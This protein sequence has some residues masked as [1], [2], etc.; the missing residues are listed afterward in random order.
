MLCYC[1]LSLPGP[2]H[3][4]LLHGLKCVAI[5]I[6]AICLPSLPLP[7]VCE[8]IAQH[9]TSSSQT[10]FLIL[11]R[12]EFQW[13]C[14]VV[15]PWRTRLAGEWDVWWR[16]DSIRVLHLWGNKFTQN[17]LARIRSRKVFAAI[18]CINIE[19][20]MHFFNITHIY[21]YQVVHSVTVLSVQ[22]ESLH[23]PAG[24]DG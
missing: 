21:F 23:T 1:P 8:T 5:P 17:K 15:L 20:C 14:F 7:H 12:R 18:S 10:N 24:P 4:S 6:P 19:S 3:P 2:L 11:C 13:K 22:P 9:T 16:E